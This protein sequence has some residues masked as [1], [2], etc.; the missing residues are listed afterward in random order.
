MRSQPD[1]EQRN[2]TTSYESYT[3]DRAKK[4]FPEFNWTSFFRGLLA[5]NETGREPSTQQF[6]HKFVLLQS[7][8]YAPKLNEWL[9][10]YNKDKMKLRDLVNYVIYRLVTPYMIFAGPEITKADRKFEN[11]QQNNIRRHAKTAMTFDYLSSVSLPNSQNAVN[12]VSDQ[13]MQCANFIMGMLPYVTGRLYVDDSFPTVARDNVRLMA[14][15]VLAAFRGMLAGL[16]WM[17]DISKLN[18]YNKIDNMIKNVAYPDFEQH[19]QQLDEYYAELID[20]AKGVDPKEYEAFF[21]YVKILVAYQTRTMFRQVLTPGDRNDFLMSPVV[22]NDWYQ[23]ERNSITFPAAQLAPPFYSY[24]FPEAV[25]YGA[26][27]ATVGH[28][29]THGFDDEGVQ[30][31]ANGTLNTWMTEK[32]QSGFQKMAQCVVDQYSGFCYPKACISG[33]DTQGENIADNGGLKAAYQAYKAWTF[34]HGDEPRLPDFPLFTADQIFFI[35]YG[36]SWCGQFSDEFLTK[37]LLTNPHSPYPARVN[38]VVMNFP[39]FGRAFGCSRGD[40]LYPEKSC[41]VW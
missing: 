4:E 36:Y 11:V 9:A 17:D 29:L 21:V 15:N 6:D 26:F 7:R 3:V 31:D 1:S 2:A 13:E 18:A 14:G 32:S 23:P 35:A 38:G 19:D 34:S 28:E 12:D 20:L 37:M 24:D 40:R 27:G 39:E 22:V 10:Q 30:Y 8:Y 5:G 25:N 16:T 41:N 33:V